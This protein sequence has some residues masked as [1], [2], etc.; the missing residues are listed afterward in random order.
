M[1]KTLMLIDGTAQIYRAFYA[2]RSL[3]DPRGRP[4]QAVFGFA[5]TLL[6]LINCYHPS[7]LVVVF[8]RPEPTRCHKIFPAYKAHRETMPEDLQAQIPL[9]KDLVNAFQ[10]KL[11]EQP[12]IEADDILVTL[13]RQAGR[14]S[15]DVLIF[16]TDKDIFQAV[17]SQVKI[18][19]PRRGGKGEYE[20][21]DQAGIERVFGVPPKQV[22]DVLALMGDTSDNIPGVPGVGEKTALELIKNFGSFEQVYASLDQ[23]KKNKLKVQLETYRDQAELSKTLVEIPEDVSLDLDW[24]KCLV[25]DV[26]PESAYSLMA[27]YG[28]KSL[29]A[30]RPPAVAAAP[31]GWTEEISISNSPTEVFKQARQNGILSIAWQETG[32]ALAADPRAAGFIPFPEEGLSSA[33]TG[34]EAWVDLLRDPRIKK[35][36]YD[37]KPLEKLLL[38][39]GDIISG[40]KIDLH[41]AAHLLDQP[42]N[43]SSDFISRVLGGPPPADQPAMAACAYLI[44]AKSI[45]GQLEDRGADRIYLEVEMPL[46]PVLAGMET[47]GIAIDAGALEAM[48]EQV[49]RELEQAEKEIQVM[50]GREFNVRSTQQLADVLFNQMKLS[51]KKKNKTGSSTSVEVLESLA[52][53]HP[54]PRKVLT[55][56]QLQKLKSTYLDV[57]PGLLDPRDG[58]L[59]TTFHQAGTATGRLSSSAP[60]LQNIPIRTERGRAIRRMFVAAGPEQRM[61]SAD[62]SQIELRLLAHISQ[63]TQMCSDFDTGLDIHRAMASEIFSVTRD[64]VTSEMRQQAKTSNFGITYGVSPYGLAR[65]LGVSPGRARGFIDGFYQRYSGVRGYLDEL[66]KEARRNGYVTTLMGR[67]RLVPDINSA[68]RNIREAAERIAINTPIQGSAA[69]FIKLAMIQIDRELRTG[70]WN[71]RMIL[72]VHDELL[73]EGPESEM[74]E[75]QERVVALMGRV[76]SLRVALV[77]EAAWGRNWMEAHA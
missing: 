28:F 3:T 66:I 12:G 70:K 36:T 54:L 55:Y 34:R 48:S 26:I 52:A 37:F 58:R 60:N 25:P 17:T 30:S 21:L 32:V 62:Y 46:L 11:Y 68:N 56:R 13:A 74:M 10:L 65:Q 6:N 16:T 43:R 41:L 40:P 15:M 5:N 1:S 67:R 7:H 31:A 27:E 20:L 14:K 77:V 39:T 38:K 35:I 71:S 4:V 49:G 8:D 50:A 57:L 76:Y 33:L 45:P 73:F 44:I 42:A 19:R 69:E 2:I 24:E 72:Q 63:D 75:L 47:E 22:A 61:L 51:P 23:V 18:L 29:L 59:H 9:V 64:Q 53:V